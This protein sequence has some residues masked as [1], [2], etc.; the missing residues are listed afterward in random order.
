MSKRLALALSWN[1]LASE[2]RAGLAAAIERERQAARDEA[3][4][5]RDDER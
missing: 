3:S 1:K 2:L 5:T 4:G